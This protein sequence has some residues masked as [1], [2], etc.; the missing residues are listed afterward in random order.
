MLTEA[1]HKRP[2]A[3]NERRSGG[4]TLLEILTAMVILAIVVTLVFGSFNGVFS[5]ANAIN[6]GSDLFEMG[7]GCL[8]RIS[9]D[10]QAIH[11]SLY[12]RYKIPDMDAEPDPYRVFA[13][14]ES[15]GGGSFARLRFT[16]LSHLPLN[17]DPREGIAQIVYYAQQTEDREIILRRSD[18]LFPYPEFEENTTDP[19]M[20]EKVRTFEMIYY[21]A[22]GR[23][24]SEWNSD[25]DDFEYGTP[26]SVSIRL[27]VGTQDESFTFSTEI[28]LPMYR[29]EPV[30]R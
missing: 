7:S 10:L 21:D 26:R 6:A 14:Q 27:V 1:N 19:V 18:H 3:I 24:Y 2:F 20:C 28:R 15:L 30:K 11:V 9:N 5:N 25:D 17:Q 8:A 4:F 16:S 29:Y 23:E 13:D 12:P 22:E